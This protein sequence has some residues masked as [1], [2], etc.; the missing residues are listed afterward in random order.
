MGE[1]VRRQFHLGFVI[2][3]FMS[4]DLTLED[5]TVLR[6]LLDFRD[7]NKM[8]TFIENNEVW[9][10]VRYSSVVDDLRFLKLRNN[11]V[12]G[13]IFSRLSGR[14]RDEQRRMYN[15]DNVNQ[16]PIKKK[17]VKTIH[18]TKIYVSFNKE[19]LN[20][21]LDADGKVSDSEEEG[22]LEEFVTTQE[23][24][25]SVF[26]YDKKVSNK[27]VEEKKPLL[28]VTYDI[29]NNILSIDGCPFKHKI[30]GK[31]DVQNKVLKNVEKYLLEIHA[32]TF[33]KN[34]TLDEVWS[35]GKRL[36]VFDIM[37]GN[38]DKIQDVLIKAT[39][40][41]RDFNANKPKKQEN[42]QSFIYN[43]M[44]KK[45][46][47]V[48]VCSGRTPDVSDLSL[49]KIKSTI[50]E[51]TRSLLETYYPKGW[52]LRDYWLNLRDVYRYAYKYWENLKHFNN[53][54]WCYKT[55]YHFM[56]DYLDFI[57]DGAITSSRVIGLNGF[58]WINFV[59]YVERTKDIVLLDAN[60]LK[61]YENV[62]G[63]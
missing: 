35:E 9:Y 60:G 51:R 28:P 26:N 13:L 63:L 48:T 29:I 43:V 15:K 19:G 55:I 12:C 20:F 7:T 25:V 11:E 39:T 22:N 24:E 50:D 14:F 53:D 36:D 41:Y 5:I 32:G 8:R 17:I 31:T 61:K 16:Y 21:I 10:W 59:R 34:H 37:K 23:D 27:N 2:D 42:L 46:L 44:S 1:N 45:S 6:W 49:H 62:S 33:L 3:R 52:S 30:N 4:L 18:G 54:S 57:L 40:K 56:K 47:F 38:W 58:G